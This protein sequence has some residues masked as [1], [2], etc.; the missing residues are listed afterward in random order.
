MELAFENY[1]AACPVPPRQPEASPLQPRVRALDLLGAREGAAD[2]KAPRTDW[3]PSA[4]AAGR[5]QL[6]AAHPP[7]LSAELRELRGGAA[8]G[9]DV[10]PAFEKKLPELKE[11]GKLFVPR[12]GNT[13]PTLWDRLRSK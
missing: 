8:A 9:D 4:R 5:V 6:H 7:R 12:K 11:A 10:G 13:G 3:A 1:D 2:T